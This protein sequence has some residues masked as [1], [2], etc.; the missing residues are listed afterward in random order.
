M[1]KPDKTRLIYLYASSKED[2]LRYEEMARQKGT[3]LSKF[4]IGLIEDH[5]NEPSTPRELTSEVETLR[6][7]ISGLLEE[8]NR[9]TLL[10]E[11]YEMELQ[12]FRSAPFAENGYGGLRN[13]DPKL[14]QIL[15]S[16]TTPEPRLI[17]LLK[18][19]QK[20]PMQIRVLSRQL[21]A[22]EAYRL[23]TKTARGWRWVG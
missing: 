22:L 11:R 8:L 15:K 6:E 9:K 3:P 4:L 1:T 5:L 16:G 19:D 13:Y 12:K 17:E 18:I 2:K 7:Q 21:E 23:V 14:V 20:E 10:L